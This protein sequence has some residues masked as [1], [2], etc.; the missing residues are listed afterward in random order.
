MAEENPSVEGALDPVE[1]PPPAVEPLIAPEVVVPVKTATAE[2]PVEV[3][4]VEA[5]VEAPAGEEAAAEAPATEAA[6]ETPAETPE[7]PAEEAAAEEP[8]EPVKPVYE[9]FKLPEGIQA[10]P[11]QIEQF[12]DT[13]GK[14]GL[15]QE[16]GQELMDLHATALKE[17]N[18]S[19]LERQTDTFNTMR[20]D[21]KQQFYDRHPNDHNTVLDDAKLA[22]STTI[23]NVDKRKAFWGAL[24]MTGAG[25]HPDVVEGLAAIGK[26]FREAG[27]PPKGLPANPT[28]GMKPGDRRYGVR[29]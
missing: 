27:A 11:E 12:T 15:T 10:A 21:W 1:T 4:P 6:A 14:Y 9:A 22:V 23:K 7:A 8:A 24:G 17:M 2:A 25:D 29:N 19:L 5:A 3:A 20:N 28:A 16:A 13:I 18:D 26:R